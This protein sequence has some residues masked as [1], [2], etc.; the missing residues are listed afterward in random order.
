[1]LEFKIALKAIIQKD[2]KILALKRS[3]SEEVFTELWDIPGGRINFGEKP[4][5]ALVREVMEET[6]L[7][8]KV[9]PRPWTIWSFM[10]N[11]NKQVVGITMLADYVEGKVKLSEEHTEYRWILPAEFTE[12]NAD[13]SLKAEIAKFVEQ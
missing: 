7:T 9:N 5:E 2:G 8:V 6:G 3:N 4:V 13:P 10:A 11:E 1:M 12:L